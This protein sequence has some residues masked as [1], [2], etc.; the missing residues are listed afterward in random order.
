[1]SSKLSIATPEALRQAV[2]TREDLKNPNLLQL[3]VRGDVDAETSNFRSAC[4]ERVMTELWQVTDAE[5]KMPDVQTTSD[6]EELRAMI[7][8]AY[9]QG[10]AHDD[11]VRSYVQRDLELQRTRSEVES[12]LNIW[13]N[14]KPA[15][16]TF[17]Q[18]LPSGR[19]LSNAAAMA[20][21]TL[22][23]VD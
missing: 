15:I 8:R 2:I 23:P 3:Y 4:V 11:L 9:T 17:I 18:W 1:M 5:T 13:R 16:E 12:F 21:T 7:V 19:A 10:Q 14:I 6:A 22:A 20:D